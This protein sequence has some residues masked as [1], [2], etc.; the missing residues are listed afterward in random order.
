MDMPDVKLKEKAYVMPQK[1]EAYDQFM[2]GWSRSVAKEFVNWLKVPSGKRWLDVGCGTGPLTQEIL[3]QASPSMVKAIDPS[4]DYI[5]FVRD[6]LQEDSRVA[7]EVADAESLFL[8]KET[9]DVVVS[10]LTLNFIP[11]PDVG[12]DAMKRVTDLHGIVAGYVWDYAG[13]MEPLRLLWDTAAELDPKAADF[14]EGKR[15]SFCEPDWLKELFIE[16]SLDEVDVHP[17]D[18]KL[19]FANFDDYWLPFRG[20]QGPAPIYVTSLSN[21]QRLK[22]EG[23]LREKIKPA[24]GGVIEMD[25]RAWAVKGIRVKK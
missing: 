2:G 16:T 11:Q 12:L 24:K 22:L 25:A 23:R 15:F 21:D 3:N 14:D 5:N 10:G 6:L 7:F 8:E 9:Y 18:V 17:I 13:K 1:A 19:R 20:G 4:W